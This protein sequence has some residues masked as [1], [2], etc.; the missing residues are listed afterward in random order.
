M[1]IDTMRMAIASV[2]PGVRWKARAQSMP[3][4]QVFAIYKKFQSD[5]KFDK[6]KKTKKVQKNEEPT[7]YQYTI[8]DYI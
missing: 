5:G 6:K 8:F 3:D 2:Y 7:Y 1:T 4:N